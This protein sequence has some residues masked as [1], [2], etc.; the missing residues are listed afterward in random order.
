MHEPLCVEIRMATPIVVPSHIK[1]LDGL[2]AWARVEEAIAD[3]IG[4]P[5]CYG[6][7]NDLPLAKHESGDQ[8]VFKASTFQYE[9]SGERFE[10]HRIKR[11][12]VADYAQ[13]WMREAIA[14]SRKS[15]IRV[16]TKSGDTK[17]GL[18]PFSMRQ[19]DV[20]RAWCIGEKAGVE[21]LLRHVVTFGKGR[22]CGAGLVVSINV[23]R[24]ENALQFWDRRPMPLQVSDDVVGRYAPGLH[25]L[26]A[27]Y[28]DT[29]NTQ[30]C[31]LPL[32]QGA[33]GFF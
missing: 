15:R 9:W 29:R 32:K 20:A 21:R 10:R 4:V 17:A 5:E 24:D 2:L 11:Q 30:E 8:W 3:G 28:W 13:S 18:Y 25:P 22:K 12:H 31:M 26:Q 27:P 7:Q 33:A 19:C 14:S 6:L 1:C 16:D 23:A